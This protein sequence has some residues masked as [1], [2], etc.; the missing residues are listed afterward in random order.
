MAVD[1][2]RVLLNQI[3]ATFLRDQGE[4]VR[5][6]WLYIMRVIWQIRNRTGGDDDQIENQQTRELYPWFADVQAPQF[7]QIP[8]FS[9]GEKTEY[10]QPFQ[11]EKPE[12]IFPS[13]YVPFATV[14]FFS[15]S[16]DHTTAGNEIIEATSNITVMLNATPDSE[17]RVTVKRNTA[18]GIVTIDG[19]GKN[20]DG[21]ATY[22]L[23]VNYDS[24]TVIFSPD[25]NEWLII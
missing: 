19:N 25:S 13:F 14:P 7:S 6:F 17:E 8:Q 24:A 5:D 12:T 16:A 22:D 20:I 2:D 15:V 11:T 10:Y 4:E 18:A 23:T 3:P 21:A 9:H 1:I